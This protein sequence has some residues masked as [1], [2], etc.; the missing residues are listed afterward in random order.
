MVPRPGSFPKCVGAAVL[1]GVLAT[2]ASPANA[3]GHPG[4]NESLLTWTNYF[5]A[6]SGVA[7][8][9]TDP[10]LDRGATQHSC[11]MLRNGVSNQ[12]PP[13]SDGATDA[14]AVA[15]R[16][17]NIAAATSTVTNGY[18]TGLWMSAPFHAIGMLR[19]GLARIG[20]GRC[21][22]DPTTTSTQP[23]K[24]AAT[25]DVLSGVTTAAPN[26]PITFP[27]NRSITHLRRFVTET[28]NPV[29]LC[30]WAGGAGLPV[31][32]LMPEP[33]GEPTAAITGPAGQLE[34]C[35]LHA[36]NTSGTA[37]DLLDADN[38]VVVVPRRPLLDGAH[39]VRITTADRVVEWSFTVHPDGGATAS[40]DPL[41]QPSQF[42]PLNPLRIADSRRGRG[43]HR[44]DSET[45]QRL[46]VTGR[47]GIPE[48][49]TAVAVT[50]T[51][52]DTT[53]DGYLQIYPC[54]TGTDT[55]ALNWAGHNQTV[56]SST[57][58]AL[59]DDG[60]V[61][62]QASD[63]THLVV[64]TVG[65]FGA[66]GSSRFTPITPTRVADTRTPAR[67]LTAGSTLNVPIRTPGGGADNA[68]AAAVNVT[69]VNATGDGSLS[70]YPC[71]TYRT[72]ATTV[73][74][75][76]A[77]VAGAA[78]IAGLRDGALCVHTTAAVDVIVDVTGWFG[79]GGLRYQA[80]APL[81]IGDT[82]TTHWDDSLGRVG[83]ALD[84]GE[85]LRVPVDETRNAPEDI[86]AVAL[87]ITAVG[88][89]GPGLVV[90]YPGAPTRP[91]TSTLNLTGPATT[92]N[93]YLGGVGEGSVV[94]SHSTGGH[95]LVDLTGLW[96][97]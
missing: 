37:H 94:I 44:L 35:V 13:G 93:S 69:A 17:G 59:D 58:A 36:G 60:G 3:A 29:E 25:I 73:H 48:G 72:N 92:A 76:A 86:G 53:G 39:Q 31:F 5:R 51:A 47:N 65:W 6:Q 74:Y 27:G 19:P 87:T 91:A 54:G 75:R 4:D 38:A 33:P 95:L 20:S 88:H 52:T 2:A 46:Q 68:V 41:G 34:V 83:A 18:L 80:V 9:D 63:T 12:Q 57:I 85:V 43:L 84:A 49:A 26:E 77:S 62:F 90:V 10:D 30:G 55:S 97:R 56:T 67:R 32:A 89:R 71:G 50:M 70:V 96:V 16:N 15:G 11:W 8:V 24:S 21:D 40:I 14:G 79:P 82:R 64:D 28:P 81:R 23:W 45:A 66:G 61:C 22:A 78:T 7:L 1:A 42:Q